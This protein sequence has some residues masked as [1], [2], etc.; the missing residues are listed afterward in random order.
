MV[1]RQF[2]KLKV[3]SSNLVCRSLKINS[4]VSFFNYNEIWTSSWH[5]KLNV[6]Y[7]F[8]GVHRCTMIP[9]AWLPTLSFYKL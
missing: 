7:V 5:L 1:E 6:P 2:S 9:Q 3:A 4:M 8:F